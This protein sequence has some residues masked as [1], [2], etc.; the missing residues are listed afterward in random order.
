M[1]QHYSSFMFWF[2]GWKTCGIFAPWLGTEPIPNALEG[3]VL[4]TGPPGKSLGVRTFLV[5]IPINLY[6]ATGSNEKKKAEEGSMAAL[7]TCQILC[8]GLPKWR[9]GKESTCQC[10]KYKRCKSRRSPGEGNGNLLQY[11]CLENPMDRG[12]WR[13][14]VH[15]VIKKRTWLSYW[16]QIL[17]I[18]FLI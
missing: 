1:L 4:T 10:Q 6:I 8:L 5:W 3:K 16:T 2:S 18:H 9:S 17:C 13:A 15:G 7:T 11:S 14:A 12:A